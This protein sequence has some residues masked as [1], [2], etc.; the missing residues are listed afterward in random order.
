MLKA[1]AGKVT[2]KVMPP[3]ILEWT[4]GRNLLQALGKRK[5]GAVSASCNLIKADK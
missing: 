4:I 3:M 2:A 1:D 5:E